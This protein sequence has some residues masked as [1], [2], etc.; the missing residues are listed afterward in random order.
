MPQMQIRDLG[1]CII[2]WN[3]LEVGK[4]IGNVKVKFEQATADV[5]EDQ[6]GLTK[7]DLVTMGYKSQEVT[8][9]ATR[10]TLSQ[11]ETVTHNAVKTN[12][13]V[14]FFNAAGE[15]LYDLSEELILK[16]AQDGAAVADANQWWHFMK[17][18]PITKLDVGYGVKDQRVW[19]I[20]FTVFPSLGTGSDFGLTHRIGPAIP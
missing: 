3:S 11:I 10:L 6:M 7:V 4:S 12:Q 2:V 17:A 16:P 13:S 8:V 5:Q 15:D 14:E 18:Y 19:D 1:P 9:P 20:T